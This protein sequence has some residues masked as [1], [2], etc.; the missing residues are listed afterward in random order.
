M[1]LRKKIK[2]VQSAQDAVVLPSP[3]SFGVRSRSPVPDRK[4]A[5]AEAPRVLDAIQ[6][7]SRDQGSPVSVDESGYESLSPGRDFA[8]QSASPPAA[9]GQGVSSPAVLRRS[10]FGSTAGLFASPVARRP[11]QKPLVAIDEEDEGL[12]FC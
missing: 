4:G 10:S 7:D 2:T 9:P 1:A 6:E 3:I 8:D 12:F 5:Q 11:E